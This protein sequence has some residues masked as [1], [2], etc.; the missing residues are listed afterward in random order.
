[1]I[2]NDNLASKV[3][4][5]IVYDKLTS[6]GGRNSGEFYLILKDKETN[7][8]FSLI[9]RPETY[10]QARN[11]QILRFEL[12]NR[13]VGVPTKDWNPLAW[14]LIAFVGAILMLCSIPNFIIF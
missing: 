8:I 2:K 7:I 4:D 14:L 1:M 12:E 3:R 13:L 10:S 11:G 9:V 5:C 6:S